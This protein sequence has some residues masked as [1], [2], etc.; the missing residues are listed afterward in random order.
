MKKSETAVSVFL[1]GFNCSQAVLSAYAK[2]F[3]LSESSAFKIACGF[4]AG[5]G[6]LQETCG[7]VSG[8]IMVLGLAHGKSSKEEDNLKELTYGLVKEF[9]RLFIQK[10]K[11]T[12]CRELLGCDLNTE[13]GRAIFR[14]NNLSE[15]ICAGCVRDAV[16]L[17][18]SLLGNV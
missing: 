17:L 16:E 1:E 13:S 14:Q 15:N 10:R 18:E 6:R 7:A 5:M 2:D 3:N 8:A 11:T 4:G 12:Q 9:N